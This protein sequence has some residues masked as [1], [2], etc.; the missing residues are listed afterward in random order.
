MKSAA[1][2]ALLTL[3]LTLALTGTSACAT[4]DAAAPVEVSQ[5]LV[6]G[7][8]SLGAE[9]T[10]TRGASRTIV[11]GRLTLDP[12][13]T[14]RLRYDYHLGGAPAAHVWSSGLAGTWEAAPGDPMAV[15]FVIVD[16]RST[17]VAIVPSQGRMDVTF[18]GLA[19]RFERAPD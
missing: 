12:D 6:A 1:V 8:W 2:K 18:M 19:M 15:R 17:A 4:H 7:A 16:D 9:V 14:W 3:A 11:A 13:G 10:D 5:V